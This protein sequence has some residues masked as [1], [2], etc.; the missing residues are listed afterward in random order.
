M[1]LRVAPGDVLSAVRT[2]RGS[3]LVKFAEPDYRMQASAVPNDPGFNL[4]WADENIGQAIRTQEPPSELLGEPVLGTPGADDGAE[5]AW[6]L[7]TGS[8]EI[9]VGEVDTGVD[10]THP[11][12]A[13]NIWTNPGNI[14]G[15]EAGTH[16][17]NAVE[18]SCDPNDND[19][20]YGGHGTHVAGIIGAVGNNGIGVTGINWRTTILPVKWLDSAS[21]GNT[22]TLI[23][24]LQ[25]LLK[26]KEEGVNLR[27]VNDSATFEGP[28]GSQMLGS[29]IEAL[30]KANILFVNAA[31]N[32]YESDDK[33]PLERYPCDYQLANELCVTATNDN[34]AL[35]P[36]ANY[37]V[38][39]VNLGAPGVSI[40]STLRENKYGYLSGGSMAAA[41]V[42]GAAALILSVEPTLSSSAL[43]ADILD[44]VDKLPSLAGKVS[45]GGRLD[46]CKAIPGCPSEAPTLTTGKASSVT[47]T[48]AT[49]QATVNPNGGAIGECRFEYGTT[50]S[51]GSSVPCDS[52]PGA[53]EAPV[54]ISAV[55]GELQAATIY[56][57]RIVASNAAGTSYGAA[58]SLTTEVA[59][60]TQQV[61]S[62][63]P[64]QTSPGAGTTPSQGVLP[65]TE[66]NPSYIPGPQLV[67]KSLRESRSGA[68]L[69]VVNCPAAR[70]NCIGTITLR[71]V[72]L[73][74]SAKT[75]RARRT[76]LL[77]VA[78]GT[79]E[80]PGGHSIQ[81]ELQLSA[82]VRAL[83]KRSRVLRATAA[84][85]AHDVNGLL[86]TTGAI[87][88]IWAPRTSDTA[89]KWGAQK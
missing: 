78:H 40:Y 53:G 29:E 63:S 12:L 44:N 33:E 1:E 11:D 55:L 37:G 14:G 85:A 7:T 20:A 32:S 79:F 67:N 21:A 66:A 88:T 60:P 77:T 82:T 46:V 81:L 27:V 84:I 41:Q 49:L 89:A 57:F 70:S 65:S 52:V 24:A 69:V 68:V 87:V 45:S 74:T 50:S 38:K 10:Y 18:Q 15:C 30:G 47:Q 34:D 73:V 83:L 35:P 31:G 6:S 19:V 54:G 22:S 8:R 28:A 4:Q 13:A 42:S 62:T 72:A 23:E 5:R 80:V 16:G 76:T 3:R 2:L 25:W 58:R 9:V 59:P 36:W 26:A 43:R 75:H 17:Y 64:S 48:S 51:Y 86:P 61:L 56:Y 39:T 71:A